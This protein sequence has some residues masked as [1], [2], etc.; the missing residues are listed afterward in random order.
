MQKNLCLFASC[1]LICRAQSTQA[2]SN[3]ISNF[4]STE[5]QKYWEISFFDMDIKSIHILAAAY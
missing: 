4:N 1:G 5:Y 3:S 2:V